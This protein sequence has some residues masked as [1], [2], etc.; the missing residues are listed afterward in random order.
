VS[1][2]LI[3]ADDVGRGVD[4]ARHEAVEVHRHGVDQTHV[5]GAL[6]LQVIADEGLQC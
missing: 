6:V 3:A 2:A 1:G 5:I 4:E